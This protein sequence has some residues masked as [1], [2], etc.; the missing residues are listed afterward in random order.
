MNH[1][2]GKARKGG[3]LADRADR[4]LIATVDGAGLPRVATASRISPVPGRSAVVVDAWFC[5]GTLANLEVNRKTSLV[6]YD[7]RADRGHQ[8]LGETETVEEVAMMNGYAPGREGDA[9]PQVERRLVV[10]VDRIIGF[11]NAPHPDTEE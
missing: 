7:R 1:G 11:R 8:L 10:R 3:A 6:L 5:P 4:P 9:L 2:P